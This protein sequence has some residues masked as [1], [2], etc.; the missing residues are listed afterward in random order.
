MVNVV[1][2]LDCLRGQEVR[3]CLIGFAGEDMVKEMG[4]I[5]TL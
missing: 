4:M 3:D 5:G 1:F 2:S